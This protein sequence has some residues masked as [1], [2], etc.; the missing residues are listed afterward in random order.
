MKIIY[1]HGYNGCPN[2]AKLDMLRRKF[3]TEEIIAPLHNN[4]PEE[5]FDVYDRISKEMVDY[6]D[7]ILGSS[8]G[9]F[10]AN[11]FSLKYKISAVLVNPVVNPSVK[12]KQ[13]G[14]LRSLDYIPFEQE[15]ASGGISPRIVLLAQNDEVLDYREAQNYYSQQCE[16]LTFPNGEH[17][18]ND[19][20]SLDRI[21]DSLSALWISAVSMGISSD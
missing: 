17:R 21:H 10:W 4:H 20:E 12:L 13:L 1:I 2:G 7:V 5:I 15:I 3:K 9:G 16:V 6:D 19:S 11:Y 8:L 14:Y 18:M